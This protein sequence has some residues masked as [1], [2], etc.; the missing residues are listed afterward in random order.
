MCINVWNYEI[1]FLSLRFIVLSVFVKM[2]IIWKLILLGTFNL[3]G[4]IF[5]SLFRLLLC[6]FSFYLLEC[7][8]FWVCLACL[9]T[10]DFQPLY[11]GALLWYS[12]SIWPF[13]L[14]TLF[15]EVSTLFWC[16]S[17]EFY[18]SSTMIK[19]NL[20]SNQ[21]FWFSDSSFTN[22]FACHWLR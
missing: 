15:P 18:N 6:M 5:C 10:Q 14:L 3:K 2:H 9:F 22:L 20:P 16:S 13:I 17:N 4:R 7:A 11:F 8:L 1:F 21:N 12:S 19:K